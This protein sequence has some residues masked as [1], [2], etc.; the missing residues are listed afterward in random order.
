LAVVGAG[1]IE[2]LLIKHP[3]ETLER[4]L[5]EAR[6]TPNFRT[7]F[8]CVWTTRMAPMVKDRVDAALTVYGGNL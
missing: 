2:D 8:R 6:R 1:A 7:A 4:I 5:A 3:E